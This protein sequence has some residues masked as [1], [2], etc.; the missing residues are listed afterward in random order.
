MRRLMLFLRGA[1][2]LAL[3][4]VV[5]VAVPALLSWWVLGGGFGW[6][7]VVAGVVGGAML[8]GLGGLTLGWGMGRFRKP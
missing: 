8:I 3:V 7:N 2:P 6:R 4:G 1:L 5:L